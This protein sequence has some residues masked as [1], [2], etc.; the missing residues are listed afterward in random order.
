MKRHLLN[1]CGGTLLV[2][3]MTPTV[4][5]QTLEN[6]L[7]QARNV[8]AEETRLIEQRR[9]AYSAAPAAEQER[10]MKDVEGKRAQV[11]ASVNRIGE[12]V[13]A[14]EVRI[15][16]LSGQLR[17]KI[18][19]LGMT[20]LIGL[21]RQVAGDVAT[22]MEQ[23]LITTQLASGAD[24]VEYLR[25]YST[26]R[27]VPT[28]AELERLWLEIQ[29]ENTASGQVARYTANVVQP[30]GNPVSAQVVRI[31][32][33]TAIANGLYT[34]FL[35][36]LG[37]LR[38]YPRQLPDEF[39]EVGQRLQNASSGYVDAV[40]DPARGVLMNLYVERP[41]WGERIHLGE[42]VGY[43]IIVVGV[44]GALA[45]VFQ[46]IY[47]SFARIAVSVQMRNLQKP[48]ANN[49]LG[50]VLLA[51]KG[52]V[53][54]IEE[55]ADVAE[56]RISEAVMKEVP[57]LERFQAFL[58]LA[59]AAGPL[60]GLVG[61]VV[62]MIITFQSITESGS[63]D[64]KLMATGI[65]Q[66]MIATVLGLGI[67]VP[68]LFANALLQSLSRGIVHILDEQSTGLLAE[69]IEKARHV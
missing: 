25:A 45:F 24:R 7:E 39:M 60:L 19:E 59:V 30:N 14:N 6:L 64:P 52:D 16:E 57:R 27:T 21:S 48:T 47:L 53:K 41:T 8:R 67:A 61:T 46:L 51:F 35:P 3:S 12:Q 10:L 49:A 62:G 50:R 23:S 31:G 11:Q 42:A 5:A 9:S 34:A 20:E 55:N 36:E 54:K 38:I 22:F 43:V 18:S 58:R 2:L 37:K 1:V 33:F 66:A 69:N 65:G 63:S 13:S 15:N 68:L 26:S 28:I 44:A 29:Q 4:Q 17:D 32:P 40:V 56:L